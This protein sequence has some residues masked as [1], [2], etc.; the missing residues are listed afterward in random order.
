MRKLL[1]QLHIYVGLVN[2]VFLMVL[3]VVGVVMTMSVDPRTQKTT[4]QPDET[5]EYLFHP[6]GDLDDAAIATIAYNNFADDTFSPDPSPHRNGEHHLTFTWRG[7]NGRLEVIF[8]EERRQLRIERY[9]V[10]TPEFVSRMHTIGAATPSKSLPL[11]MWRVYV[12]FAM[13]SLVFMSLTG[14]YLWMSER[15][16]VRWAQAVFAVSLATSVVLY[17]SVQ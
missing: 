15:W 3:G 9:S 11:K 2:F 12:E 6:P 1:L 16:S 14:F 8:L 5:K 7:P 10:S 4:P 13:V 17:W